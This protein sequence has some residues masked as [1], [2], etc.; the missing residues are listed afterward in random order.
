MSFLLLSQ[1]LRRHAELNKCSQGLRR[2]DLV[3]K[4]SQGLRRHDEVNK[5]SQGLRRVADMMKNRLKHKS[6]KIRWPLVNRAK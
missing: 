3:N 4:C 5:C 1:G 2:H 6:N